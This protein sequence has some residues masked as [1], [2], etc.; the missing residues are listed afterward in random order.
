MRKFLTRSMMTAGLLLAGSAMA[1]SASENA[2]AEEMSAG[3]FMVDT[4]SNFEDAAADLQDAV[5]N[6]GLVID[7]TGFIGDMLART[8]EAVGAKSPYM[9][10]QYLHFCSAKHTH[11]AVAADVKNLAICPYV[12]FVYEVAEEGKPV[13]VGYRRPVGV[14]NPASKAALAD[15]ETLLKEIVEEAAR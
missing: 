3:F 15:I 13:Q 11:A 1:L 4:Q 14:D 7:Y 8:G 2:K 12:V 10:A 6:R 5:I 9:N